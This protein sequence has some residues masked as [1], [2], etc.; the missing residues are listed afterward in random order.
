MIYVDVPPAL[1]GFALLSATDTFSDRLPD[2]TIHSSLSH[3][4]DSFMQE[5]HLALFENVRY[6][7]ITH[8]AIYDGDWSNPNT[9]HNG[10][11]PTTGARVLITH[12]QDVRVDGM[13]AARLASIRVD[14]TLSFHTAVNTELKVDTVVVGAT[15]SFVMGTAATPIQGN[16]KARLL[17]TN[18]G[19]INRVVDPFGISRGLI[20]HGVASIYG[21][22]VTSYVALLAPATVGATVLTLK[23]APTNWK[24]GDTIVIAATTAG[25]AQNEE[26]QIAAI[27][28]NIVTLNQALAYAHVAPSAEFDVHVANV[29][30]N[31]VIE[32]ESQV[33][34]RRGHVMF[35]H[36]RNVHIEYGGF[37]HLGR[38]NKSV[39]VNDSVVNKTDWTLQPG[40]GTNQRARYPVHFHR[41][42]T[43]IDGNPST[44]LGSAV[45]DAPGWGYV[46]HS[47]YVDMTNN[48]AYAVNG[49]SFATEVGD[50]TGTFLGNIAI[51]TTG[52][53]EHEESRTEIQ[54]FGHSGEGFWFQGVGIHVV[55]NISAGNVASAYLY[56]ARSITD[57]GVKKEFLT[58]NL[59]D[60]SIAG[61]AP[62]IDV[63]A[64]PLFEF[65]NNV[66]YAS[67]EGLATW[68]HLETSDPTLSG[69]VQ[70]S[71]FWNNSLG[72]NL[73]YTR[74]TVLRNLTITH[75]TVAT[76]PMNGL[77]G[78]DLTENITFENLTVSGYRIGIIVPRR[79]HN[80]IDGGQYN[81]ETDIY[82]R[83]AG[84]R[85]TLITGFSYTPRIS[86]IMDPSLTGEEVV[87][88]FG[89]D[90]VT[91][92]F[93]PFANQRLYY[94]QQA[95]DAVPF[96][97]PIE[98]LPGEYVGLTNQQLWTQYGVA[99]NSAI[100]PS[101][102]YTVPEIVGLIAPADT[103]APTVT[104]F[105]PSSGS[106]SVPTTTAATVTFSE[107]M[108]ASSITAS[109]VFLR[110][111]SGA[112]VSATVSYN[113]ANYTATITPSTAL[114]SS[115]TYTIVV[116]GGALAVKD[117]AGN[118]LAADV[119]S[120][121][122]TAAPTQSSLWTNSPTPAIIDTGDTAAVELGVRFSSTIDGFIT[123]IRFY[124][125]VA[126]TGI[127]TGS[128]WSAS[129]QLLATGTFVNETASGWQTLLFATPVAITAQTEYVASYHTDSGH[130]SATRNY[131]TSEF[132]NANLRVAANGGVYRYGATS[133]MP[134][135]SWLASNYWV[136]VLFTSY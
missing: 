11:V 134:T 35:M 59:P 15:G 74:R 23:S 117:S 36:N 93:G 67:E 41:T 119:T 114:S 56:F 124:K 79:G 63:G 26:R 28:G 65:R 37:Y 109:T 19:P 29:T 30:R 4:T 113:A 95:A 50:E 7:Q 1:E 75:A 49:S 108:D 85:T 101:G 115:M 69:I 44:I 110:N 80:V 118:P 129:G 92:N 31:A 111:A 52:S 68:Y 132:S 70:D 127:H 123:G 14:G 22:A 40:T 104:S 32:S 135:S 9:W 83:T 58:A 47:G 10:V 106:S 86:M 81:N 98:G 38:T 94:T 62:T 90:V 103:T 51:G 39:P 107:A 3:G 82:F 105:S 5:E 88:Y 87:R 96:P 76:Q 128:L 121:F 13:I 2:E 126:N 6:D 24:V 27:S 46:N 112:T 64:M 53:G 78:N 125:A 20:S 136:D 122:T 57:L 25:T 99:L 60:P 61:G 133:A 16:V 102:S 89:N 120:S 66:G 55:G 91:L 33:T 130:Y 71:Q 73:G 97:A 17:I 8:Y 18:D 45:V 54:D 116:K 77:K 21:A 84:N 43:V 100:A 42:G 48:V 72:V 131:F 12:G 34:D